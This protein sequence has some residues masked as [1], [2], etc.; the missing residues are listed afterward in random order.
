VDNPNRTRIRHVAAAAEPA[1]AED[2]TDWNTLIRSIHRSTRA[3][4]A[5]HGANGASG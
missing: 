5:V 2:R 4:T 1:I 3:N